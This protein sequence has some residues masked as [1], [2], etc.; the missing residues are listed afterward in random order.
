MEDEG[1]AIL[2][3]S[4]SKSESIISVDISSNEIRAKGARH[5][6]TGLY[7]N[8]SVVE[9]KLSS[10]GVEAKKNRLRAEGVRPLKQ[11]L[12]TNLVLSFLD[13]SG[14]CIGKDGLDHI[15]QGLKDNTSLISLKVS[16]N[17]IPGDGLHEL[18]KWLRYTRIR[19]L[20]IS[21]N[22]IGNTGA[23]QGT[24]YLPYWS[25]LEILDISDIR[26]S[27]KYLDKS[28]TLNNFNVAIGMEGLLKHLDGKG[29]NLV[30]LI[31][32]RNDFRIGKIPGFISFIK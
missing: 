19:E 3:E 8:N 15:I 32:D 13:V 12:E 1:I 20:D 30:S 14:N 23:L 29:V 2:S 31:L 4:I 28:S 21:K 26:I 5:L 7:H 24:D 9:L 18:F 16:K 10:I 11:L 6:I 22:P 25:S 17:D 27:C